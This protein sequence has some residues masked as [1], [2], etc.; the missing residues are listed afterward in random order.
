MASKRYTEEQLKIAVAESTSV[1][2]VMRKLGLF[3]AGGAH[4]HLSLKIKKLGY[5][6]S[7]FLGSATNSVCF[8][9][10]SWEEF[11]VKSNKN[12]R[13]PAHIVRRSLIEF[14]REYKCAI[15]GNNGEWNG[16][17]LTLQVDHVDGDKC[18]NSPENL[19]FLCPN[20]HTQTI[21][22]GSKKLKNK[23]ERIIQYKI[24]WPNKEELEKLIWQTPIRDLA[25]SLKVS[26]KAIANRCDKLGITRPSKGY[27]LKR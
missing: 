10:K 21:N 23:K 3:E 8:L 24:D 5:D 15:C 17:K 6:T 20:C 26:D 4:S 7:H 14:G 9:K 18:N 11:L 1:S 19:R 25:L 13:L 16:Q 22:Y 12:R 27:W 2:E